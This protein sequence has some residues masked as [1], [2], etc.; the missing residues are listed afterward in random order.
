MTPS[1]TPAR[2]NLVHLWPAGF[3]LTT[4]SA[5]GKWSWRE[6][7]A[8]RSQEGRE[9]DV[10][11]IHSG[12]ADPSIAGSIGLPIAVRARPD[13]PARAAGSRPGSKGRR[14]TDKAARSVI[15][16]AN[17]FPVAGALRM[18]QGPWPVAT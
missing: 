15:S 4:T 10:H 13:H 17:A 12:Q 16:S 9:P 18:P 1:T 2:T 5:A 11:H 7:T 8:R 3:G 6:R 14:S